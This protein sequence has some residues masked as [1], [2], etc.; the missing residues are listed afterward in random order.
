MNNFKKNEIIILY[1]SVDYFLPEIEKRG[2]VISELYKN[3]SLYVRSI[4]KLCKKLSLSDTFLFGSWKNHL[5]SAKLVIVFAP[6]EI[7]VIKHI[8]SINPN[9]RIIY[10]YWNPAYRIGRPTP[11][12]Y[13]LT[14]IWTFDKN[15]AQNYKLKYNNTF[16][17]D[18]IST[19]N[20]NE[21][22]DIVFVGRNK[23]RKDK[24]MDF[25][26]QFDKQGFKSLFHIV[27]HKNE[28]NPENIKELAYRDYLKLISNSKAILDIMPP[29]QVG[30]TLRPMESIFLNI[31]IITDNPH[32]AGEPFYNPNNIF[33]L[34]KD[35]DQ[36]L[37]SFL[38]LPF[39]PVDKNVLKLYDF[40]TWLERIVKD[41]EF[42]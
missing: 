36:N 26:N 39:E 27:P 40:D 6:V 21:K 2:Y 9:I 12:L 33:I 31:K 42:A 24:L 13:Q 16:Y 34:G 5:K 23:H 28:Q 10:W 15:D 30:L 32:I 14:D 19:E 4:R 41:N 38:D 8:K 29:S 22:H 20:T 11:E 37:A 17:F 1:N 25:K 3:E 35:D 18:T 7:S